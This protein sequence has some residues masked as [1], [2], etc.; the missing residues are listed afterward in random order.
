MILVPYDNR[1]WTWDGTNWTRLDI[2][3]PTVTAPTMVYDSAHSQ[4]VLWGGSGTYGSGSE[5]WTYESGS[6]TLQAAPAG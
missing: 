6:W 5:T 4:L 3:T 2:T 1:T